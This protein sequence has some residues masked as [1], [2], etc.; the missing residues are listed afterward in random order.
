MNSEGEENIDQN[1]EFWTCKKN[2]MYS[3]NINLLLTKCEAVLGNIGT[4]SG[5]YGLKA[6]RSI[7]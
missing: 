4:K 6:A 7:Q 2:L 5:W 1:P 3:K